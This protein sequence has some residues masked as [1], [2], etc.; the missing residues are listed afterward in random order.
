MCGASLIQETRAERV[1]F[2]RQDGLGSTKTRTDANGLVRDGYSYDA[3]GQTVSDPDINNVA[4]GFTGEYFDEYIS[5]QYNR[6][7]WYD[8]SSGRFVAQDPVIGSP[9]SPITLNKY[10]YANADPLNNSD[11]S[12]RFSTTEVCQTSSMIQILAMRQTANFGVK[13]MMARQT[14]KALLQAQSGVL[15]STAVI[16]ML[17]EMCYDNSRNCLLSIPVYVTGGAQMPETAWHIISS[18]LGE[19]SNNAPTPAL[20]NGYLKQSRNF[21][22]RV[23]DADMRDRFESLRGVRGTCDEYPFS[24]TLQ[25]GEAN[26]NNG[27]VSLRMVST[28]EQS[29]Q[30]GQIKAFYGFARISQDGH[31]ME[32]KFV[33][34]G[35]AGSRSYAIN[36][37]GEVKKW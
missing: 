22:D 32:S 26:F 1:L 13:Q 35:Q 3:F 24:T 21:I 14:S 16:V 4:A 6:A 19:G 36:R 30:G 33:A 12:G 27:G 11:P 10:I 2:Y 29:I 37:N 31:S 15:A 20:L 5:L 9:S 25:G 23:C 28:I 17:A 34:V 8:A 7:R 18:Q